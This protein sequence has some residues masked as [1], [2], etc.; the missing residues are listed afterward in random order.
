MPSP[1]GSFLLQLEYQCQ[2][3]AG[4]PEDIACHV[5][6]WVCFP[7]QNLPK[8]QVWKIEGRRWAEDRSQQLILP[9]LH[10]AYGDC[11][12]SICFG[13][14]DCV[15]LTATIPSVRLLGSWR[16]DLHFLMCEPQCL[17]QSRG[18]GHSYKLHGG[19]LPESP[20]EGDPF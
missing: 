14:S 2:L 16:Q 6:L 18:Q 19:L 8:P 15:M 9:C 20:C 7:L 10:L 11:V 5:F 17:P 12:S 3:A 1:G 13:P 4:S